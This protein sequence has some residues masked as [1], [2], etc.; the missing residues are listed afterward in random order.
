M[1]NI[2]I[3]IRFE[4]SA[5]RINIDLGIIIKFTTINS[6]FDLFTR[7]LHVFSFEFFSFILTTRNITKL[8]LMITRTKCRVRIISIFCINQIF[9]RMISFLNWGRIIIKR[10]NQR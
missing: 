8:F 3:L 2:A 6:F 4:N 10:F 7:C 1:F 5:Q 9:V